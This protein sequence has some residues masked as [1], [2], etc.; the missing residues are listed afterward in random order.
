MVVVDSTNETG[1]QKRCV[2]A[3]ESSM[4]LLVNLSR[5][6]NV[7]DEEISQKQLA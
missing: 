3:V 5:C 1:V 4:V 2:D 7:M 6:R